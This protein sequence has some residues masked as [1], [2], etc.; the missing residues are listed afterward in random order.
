[1]GVRVS[2]VFVAMV[3][4][5]GLLAV[6][7]WT[8]QSLS[9]VTIFA[10]IVCGW[11]VSLCLHEFAH[12][13]VAYRGGDRSVA[14]RGYLSLNPMRYS[15]PLLSIVMPLVLLV[16]GGIGL[17]GGAVYVDRSALRSRRTASMVA[18]AGPITNFALAFVLFT[19]FLFMRSTVIRHPSF[20]VA[21]AAL[22]VLQI[23]AVILN[24]LPIPPLDGFGII[25]P[26]FTDPKRPTRR[27][28]PAVFP[29][30]LLVF[31]YPGGPATSIWRAAYRVG[32]AAGVRHGAASGGIQLARF[33]TEAPNLGVFTAPSVRAS[34]D[35]TVP[36]GA[37]AN[38]A[39]ARR[40]DDRGHARREQRLRRPQPALRVARY[41]IAHQS[42]AH[43]RERSPDRR[44]VERRTG[45]GVDR[46]G[47]TTAARH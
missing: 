17:P 5:F 19:P 44:S 13:Y 2:P 39:V 1:M 23:V 46:A 28:H 32:Y 30:V 7:L 4:V 22:A 12:V 15:H 35:G 20:E 33:W 26:L 8:M 43:V 38:P 36:S 6:R 14:E 31:L 45:E 24:L 9:R 3:A 18:A 21:F 11:V 42:A 34:N 27:A 41:G 16:V 40:C 37:Q 25:E 29:L 47:W 10:F